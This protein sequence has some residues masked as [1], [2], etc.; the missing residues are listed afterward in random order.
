MALRACSPYSRPRVEN[1]GSYS[2]A[3]MPTPMTNHA[4]MNTAT[5]GAA[6]WISRP[7]ASNTAL[8]ASTGRPPNRSMRR[9][10]AGETR[11]EISSPSDSAAMTQVCDQPVARTMGSASTA[12][13]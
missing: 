1:A 3:P 13:R 7:M 5:L 4:A 11:P 6:A 2:P 9:P 8:A 12:S 10:T